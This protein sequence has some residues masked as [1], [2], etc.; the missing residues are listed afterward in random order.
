MLCPEDNQPCT[1]GGDFACYQECLNLIKP[2]PT[3]QKETK[4]LGIWFVYGTDYNAYPVSVFNDELEARRSMESYEKV[5]FWPF[6]VKWNDITG[7]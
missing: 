2:H 4:P 3:T 6:G 1:G 7:V 5:V